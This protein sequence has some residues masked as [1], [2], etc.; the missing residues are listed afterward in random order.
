[1]TLRRHDLADAVHGENVLGHCGNKVD[2]ELRKTRIIG[3]ATQA[4]Q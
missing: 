1:M 3:P 2:S 4:V